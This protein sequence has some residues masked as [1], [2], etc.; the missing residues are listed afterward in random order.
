M[1]LLYKNSYVGTT[2]D[3]KKNKTII[4]NQLFF[5][6][7]ASIIIIDGVYRYMQYIF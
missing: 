5:S 1:F 3:V 4:T 6:Y 2:V 7:F